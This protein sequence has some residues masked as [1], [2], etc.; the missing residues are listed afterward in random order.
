MLFKNPDKRAKE[1][2]NMIS[3]ERKKKH[4]QSFFV[5]GHPKFNQV[6][7]VLANDAIDV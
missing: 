1:L 2:H 3:D 7:L 5:K 6:I 4:V